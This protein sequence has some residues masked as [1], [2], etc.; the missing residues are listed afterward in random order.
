MNG[1]ASASIVKKQGNSTL[2]GNQLANLLLLRQLYRKRNNTCT[3][4]GQVVIFLNLTLALTIAAVLL[5]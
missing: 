4:V 2:F 3:A 5:S 1:V